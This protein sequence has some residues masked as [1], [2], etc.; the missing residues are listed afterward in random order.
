VIVW[1]CVASLAQEEPPTDEPPPPEMSAKTYDFA[2]LVETAEQA[3][4]ADGLAP[5][6]VFSGI[7]VP[8]DD[9]SW[10]VRNCRGGV[11]SWGSAEEA[12]HY[13]L[14]F[15]NT[16]E[17]PSFEGDSAGNPTVTLT[18]DDEL[19]RRVSWAI[20]ALKAA[21]GVRVKLRAYS[22]PQGSGAATLNTADAEKL[23]QGAT[24][25][26][27]VS[28]QLGETLL[29]QEL[30]PFQFIQAHDVSQDGTN[31]LAHATLNAGRE[32][33]AGALLLPDGK[34]WLQAWSG[35]LEMPEV[36]DVVST[37]G[38]VE[39]P[40]VKYSFVPTSALLENNGAAILDEGALGRT[41]VICSIEGK[42]PNCTL[43]CGTRTSLG[44][45]NITGMLQA[46]MPQMSWL[47]GTSLY[48]TRLGRVSPAAEAWAR[49]C[50][51]HGVTTALAAQLEGESQLLGAIVPLGPYLGV[52]VTEPSGD[53]E[54]SA[55][56]F[57][58]ARKRMADLLKSINIGR[59]PVELRVQAWRTKTVPAAVT[60]GSATLKDLQPLGSPVFDRDVQSL[61]GQRL[62]LVDME[63]AALI[64]GE[65]GGPE[66]GVAA[67]G[68]QLEWLARE[69]VS[70]T[71]IEL[72]LGLV[73][74]ERKIK[75]GD[76]AG[77]V[78]F[79]R[80]TRLPVQA[81]LDGALAVEALLCVAV[82]S[83]EGYLVVAVQRVR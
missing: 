51:L 18:C 57:N 24:L 28:G 48:E 36:R 34:V 46:E 31:T 76:D 78:K 79:E 43:D 9:A 1:L 33:V 80:A 73:E 16:G 38:K 66:I 56:E 23:A 64:V 32:L 75:S 63:L 69:G 81:E 4:I 7:E 29:V 8:L 53:S 50:V 30:K 21:A 62:G 61:S 11:R 72:R 67:W 82:P 27:V 13:V 40:R 45:V 20:N 14:Q 25:L 70:G 77:K 83:G 58:A 2:G 15:C 39:C 74:G 49:P 5:D 12:M 44:L 59:K 37:C 71:E 6:R 19:H 17:T 3:K 47:A 52:R 10:P 26:G 55:D 60:Q 22:L 68:A 41:L 35:R 42:L 65:S 54:G